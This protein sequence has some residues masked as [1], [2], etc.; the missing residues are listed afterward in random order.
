M[1]SRAI[2]LAGNE[3]GVGRT[4]MCSTTNL[5]TRSATDVLAGLSE[6]WKIGTRSGQIARK[7]ARFPLDLFLLI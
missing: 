1:V 2:V 3:S 4:V 5:A 7:W 6:F